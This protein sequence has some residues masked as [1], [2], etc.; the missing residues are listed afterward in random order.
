MNDVKDLKKSLP[1]MEATFSLDAVEGM[2]TQKI[3]D[4]VFTCKIPN[5]KAQALIEKHKA[6]LNGGLQ[7]SLDPI[8]LHMHHMLGYLRYTLTEFPKWWKES[9]MGY[10]LYDGNIVSAIYQKVM[11]HETSWME[12]VWGKEES[13]QEGKAP[14]EPHTTA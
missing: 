10:D 5:I 6:M 14:D 11:E 12:T 1:P 8:T 4:G 9:D 2:V 7:G 13:A 3:Y